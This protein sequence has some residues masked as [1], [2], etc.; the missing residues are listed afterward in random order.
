MNKPAKRKPGR[1]SL[2]KRQSFTF[3]VRE[4]VRDL[5]VAAAQS[6]NVSVS[7][8]IERRVE[9]T[10]S[11]AGIVA[12][13]FGG[14]E[15][16]QLLFAFAVA[17]QEVERATGKPWWA[18]ASTSEQ[19]RRAIDTLVIAHRPH[20][21]E[22]RKQKRGIFRQ[23]RNPCRIGPSLRSVHRPFS[24]RRCRG[25]PCNGKGATRRPKRARQGPGST[26]IVQIVIPKGQRQMKGHIRE[27][28]PGRWAIILDRASADR[29]AEAQ[30]AYLQGNEATGANRVRA[31]DI[32]D[33]GRHV[34][35]AEQNNRCA[36]LERWLDN[37]KSQ[38]SP[39][40]HERYCEIV[41]KNIVPALGAIHPT[42]LRP[43]QISDAYAKAL[44]SGR[45]DG[46]GGLAPTTVVYM[47]RL[48]KQALGQAVRWELLSETPLTRSIRR[49]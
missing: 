45:R 32:S 9:L 42:K 14:I 6:S 11:S 16:A 19:M 29:Q 37:V 41:R 40:T 20:S 25:G 35:R 27:R 49:R 3:R 26:P 4:N 46:K 21:P 47:H 28:S 2:G 33:E 12:E 5:L 36:Y 1:P 7:E 39:R 31:S 23:I 38:I 34:P 15:N 30:V 48:I 22:V 43:A 18:D 17:I 24:D 8:E 13:M 10:F 44:A